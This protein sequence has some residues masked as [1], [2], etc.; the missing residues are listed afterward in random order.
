MPEPGL[1]P[2]NPLGGT[3]PFRRHWQGFS[4]EQAQD[5][6]VAAV[7]VPR[8][9]VVPGWLPRPG[10]WRT[11]HGLTVLWTGPNQWLAQAGGDDP[12]AADKLAETLVPATTMADLS[13]AWVR[14]DLAGPRTREVLEK[15]CPLDL[16]ASVF[17]AGRVARTLM[18]HL[19]VTIAALDETGRFGLWVERSAA[20]WFLHALVQAADSTCGP[21]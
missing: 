12:A 5:A 7:S 19:T 2:S 4:I 11:T 13:D 8:R 21:D 18:D 3:A 10:R 15:L 9:G 20:R 6:F 17:P 16:H 1:A 14:L